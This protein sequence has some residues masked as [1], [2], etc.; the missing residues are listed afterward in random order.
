MPDSPIRPE[1]INRLRHSAYG[2]FAM[3]AGIKL[4]VFTPVADRPMTAH[5]I[6]DAVGVDAERLRPLLY[7]LVLAG[8]LSVDNDR[9]SNSEEANQ[10]LTRGG[11]SFMGPR[12]GSWSIFWNAALQTAESIQTGKPQAMQDWSGAPKETE[13]WLRGI[14]ASAAAAGRD[15]AARHDF[16]S[17]TNLLDVGGG[18][19]G[20][21]IAIAE[22]W[23][24]VVATVAELHGVAPITRRI[25]DEEDAGKRVKVVAANAVSDSLTGSFDVAVMQRLIQ[26]L[27]SDDVRHMLRNVSGV[28]KPGGAIYAYGGVLENSRLAPLGDAIEDNITLINTTEGQMYTEEEH[29][30]WLEEAGFVDIEISKTSFGQTC[31]SA[32]KPT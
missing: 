30:T 9:F 19:G 20:L 11:P 24:H 13:R 12:Q 15:L 23:P 3:L 5:E 16:S 6:A 7:A 28:L 18:S 8:L 1:T 17:D 32:V 4:D 21:S 31:V 26:V 29:R 22:A 10:F 27:S 14:R 2:A 25:L